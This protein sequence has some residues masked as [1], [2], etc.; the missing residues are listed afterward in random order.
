MKKVLMAIGAATCAFSTMAET[1]TL[2]SLLNEMADREALTRMPKEKFLAKAWT[3]YDRKS[4][5]NNPADGMYVEKR[6]RDW[7]KGWF[8]NADYRQYI[9][10]EENNG[11]KEYVLM[12]DDGPGYLVRWW[13]TENNKGLARIYL[14]GNPNPVIEMPLSEMIGTDKLVGEPFSFKASDDKTNPAWRG[15]NLYLPIPYAKGCKVTYD[16]RPE[17]YQINYNKFDKNVKVETFTMKGFDAAKSLIDSVGKT[18]VSRNRDVKGESQVAGAITL[19]PGSEVATKLNKGGAIKKLLVQI[20]AD[21]YQQALRSTVVKM[22]F[23]GK[24]TAWIPLGSLVGVGYSNEKNDTYY[25]KADN[26]TGTLECYYVMPFQKNAVITVKNYGSQNVEIKRFETVVDNYKWDATSRYFHATWFELRNISTQNRCDLNYVIVRGSGRF[27]GTSITIFNTCTLPNNAT[28]W[29][30]GDDK[31]YVD[32]ET[33]PSIFGT[34]TE[35]YFGYAFCRP[36]RYWNPFISQPRGEGNKK[37]GYTN[38][39]RYHFLDNVPFNESIKFDMEVWH[40]FRK[41]M[42]YAAATFFYADKNSTNSVI[43]NEASVKHKVALKRED[44]IDK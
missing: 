28:W 34:G 11:R 39:N 8:A 43:P 13:C 3:S 31:F 22:K 42:N 6:G 17:Y 33:F 14:D 23:D 5:V 18:L 38:N 4:K 26:K 20:K 29:G 30:E 36:Q 24:Q 35:D 16:R 44:V 21:D 10:I 2:K 15:H 37:H 41:N 32:G 19:K 40:P 12:E 1:V 7:G 9:R 27:V 25:V